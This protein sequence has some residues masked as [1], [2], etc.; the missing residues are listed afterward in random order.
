MVVG[1]KR[2]VAKTFNNL[3]KCKSFIKKDETTELKQ[4]WQQFAAAL[5]FGKKV[6][7]EFKH[8]KAEIR[9]RQLQNL[10]AIQWRSRADRLDRGNQIS[11]AFFERLKENY[12]KTYIETLQNDS[13]QILNTPREKLEIAK[14]FYEKL[15][16]STVIDKTQQNQFLQHVPTIVTADHNQLL[17]APVTKSKIHKVLVK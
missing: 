12:K 15:Y 14:R 7:T 1:N 16:F 10:Q 9:N 13:S 5:S 11:V 17:C 4:K 3:S 6:Y 8:V 2:K